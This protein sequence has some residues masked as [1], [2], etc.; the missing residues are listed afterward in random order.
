[1][2]ANNHCM[3]VGRLT[4]DPEFRL[5]GTTKVAT[6]SLAVDDRVKNKMTG[7]W[8]TQPMYFDY[9]AFGDQAE[10]IAQ[11]FHKGDPAIVHSESKFE[12]WTD[13]D[14]G[15]TRTKVKF[16]V[17]PFGMNFVPKP[18]GDRS[19]YKR[20]EEDSPKIPVVVGAEDEIPF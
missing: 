3:H 14:S 17:V 16:V 5:V 1:M 2:S 12:K 4:R 11:H 13:K 10:F 8:E 15:Q 20:N 19:G 9:T 7:A 18:A 6:F